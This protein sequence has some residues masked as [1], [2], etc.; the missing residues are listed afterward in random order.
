MKKFKL[1]K[2]SFITKLANGQEFSNGHRYISALNYDLAE[3]ELHKKEIPFCTVITT[4]I[5]K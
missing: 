2:F 3:K 1:F 4:Q 5:I